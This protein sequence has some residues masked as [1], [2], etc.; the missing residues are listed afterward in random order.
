M[1][2]F[3]PIDIGPSLTQESREVRCCRVFSPF[4]T[5]VLAITVDGKR[6]VYGVSEHFPDRETPVPATK[7][8]PNL[9]LVAKCGGK[10]DERPY[11]VEVSLNAGLR[12][13]CTCYGF[14]RWQS[15]KHVDALSQLLKRAAL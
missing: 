3:S 4:L 12:P 8:L 14:N 2:A 9:F 7:P 13:S 5:H 11:L 15:C 6:E 1:P 10:D